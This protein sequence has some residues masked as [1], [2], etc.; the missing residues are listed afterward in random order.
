MNY[1]QPYGNIIIKK[2]GS[3]EREGILLS[4]EPSLKGQG[5]TFVF[6]NRFQYQFVIGHHPPC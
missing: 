5:I 3:K 2:I 6:W 1:L 4:L